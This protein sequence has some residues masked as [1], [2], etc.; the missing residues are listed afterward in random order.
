MSLISATLTEPFAA[1][2]HAIETTPPL[3]GQEVAVLGPRKLGML[4]LAALR[5]YLNKHNLQFN[6][7]ALFRQNPSPTLESLAKEL[8]AKIS[9]SSQTP[10]HKFHLLFDTSGS[11]QGFLHSLKLTSGILHLKSTHGQQVCGLT[12]MADFVVDEISLQDFLVQLWVSLGL[13]KLF[14]G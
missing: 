2:L 3:E 1:A 9:I 14:R 8:G 7:T 12:R 6:T 10:Q 13:M 4:I 11:P 5:V